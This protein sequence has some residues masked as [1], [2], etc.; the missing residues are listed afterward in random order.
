[1]Y[2]DLILNGTKHNYRYVFNDSIYKR[3]EDNAIPYICRDFTGWVVPADKKGIAVCLIS[4]NGHFKITCGYSMRRKL[5]RRKINRIVSRWLKCGI[6]R[7]RD[8][9]EPF[10]EFEKYNNLSIHYCKAIISDSYMFMDGTAT[11]EQ[12]V[13]FDNI[14]RMLNEDEIEAGLKDASG[15]G[16]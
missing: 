6:L 3:L 10:P 5:T 8:K 11:D 16:C 12:N 15:K 14:V 9:E 1:M 2:D 7:E 4:L 13:F